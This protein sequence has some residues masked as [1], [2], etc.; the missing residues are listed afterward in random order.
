MAKAVPSIS[1]SAARVD[2]LPPPQIIFDTSATMQAIRQ[3]VGKVS[4]SSIPVLILA[5]MLMLPLT[6]ANAQTGKPL[7]HGSVGVSLYVMPSMQVLFNGIPQAGNS[8]TV[9]VGPDFTVH[10]NA[11]NWENPSWDLYATQLYSRA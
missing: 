9:R 3:K 4:A 2:E 8:F 6:T 11:A 10:I 5:S 1:V 7:M